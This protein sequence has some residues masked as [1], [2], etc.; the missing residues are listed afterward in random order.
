MHLKISFSVFFISQDDVLPVSLTEAG[1]PLG[2][3]RGGVDNLRDVMN[4]GVHR[5]LL[6]HLGQRRT[7][8]LLVLCSHLLFEG[9]EVDAALEYLTHL[10][11]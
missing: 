4:T 3:D 2:Y 11:D 1:K 8:S 5:W 10:F 9:L 7:E 6:P